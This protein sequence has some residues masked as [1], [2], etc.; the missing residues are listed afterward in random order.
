[1][2]PKALTWSLGRPCPSCDYMCLIQSPCIQ[3]NIYRQWCNELH[4]PHHRQPSSSPRSSILACFLAVVRLFWGRSKVPSWFVR[5]WF[6]INGW[7][8]NWVC[9]STLDLC[10]QG[11]SIGLGEA[12][13]R[14][15]VGCCLSVPPPAVCFCYFVFL[16]VLTFMCCRVFPCFVMLFV[17]KK[18]KM[19]G[20][21]H[22]SGVAHSFVRYLGSFYLII[23]NLVFPRLKVSSLKNMQNIRFIFFL[24]L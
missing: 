15:R 8:R 12:P 14:W 11:H 6:L 4:P 21:F 9:R 23:L 3:C 7:W 5:I 17:S 16:F 22:G 24:L 20:G 1:M 10:F 18:M 2:R 13:P 19:S